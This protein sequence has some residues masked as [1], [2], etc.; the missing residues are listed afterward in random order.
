MVRPVGFEPT[1][2]ADF[3]NKINIKNP[4]RE[5]LDS[6]CP[7]RVGLLANSYTKVNL[8]CEPN[9]NH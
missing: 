8:F 4:I 7:E 9:A 6:E 5:C 2:M 3:H 1:Q